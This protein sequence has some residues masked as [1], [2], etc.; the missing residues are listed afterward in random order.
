MSQED[1]EG[2]EEVQEEEEEEDKDG[3]TMMKK[4]YDRL[5]DAGREEMTEIV[6]QY[7]GWGERVG[8]EPCDRAKQDAYPFEWLFPDEDAYEGDRDDLMNTQ[9]EV[10]VECLKLE[11]RDVFAEIH[12]GHS[13]GFVACCA[14]NPF[15]P[16]PKSVYHAQRVREF[17]QATR[18]K[19]PTPTFGK[20]EVWSS[21][22]NARKRDREFGAAVEAFNTL[23]NTGD[24]SK[25]E[26]DERAQAMID[27]MRKRPLVASGDK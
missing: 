25:P 7:V 18:Y 9:M 26:D 11:G 10:Y 12:A 27:A 13:E 2:E 6:A 24:F 22:E 1:R 14:A 17:L 19:D 4:L 20:K 5:D 21:D 15:H 3:L 23:A 8:L 16:D